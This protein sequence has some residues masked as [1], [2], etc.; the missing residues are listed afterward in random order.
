MFIFLFLFGEIV[1]YPFLLSEFEVSKILED[2]A[3]VSPCSKNSLK[4]S[5][6]VK[7]S[8]FSFELLIF[9]D[10]SCIVWFTVEKKALG[11]A[12]EICSF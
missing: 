4:L 5:I 8:P 1:F 6:V 7:N 12:I 2:P 10:E 3:V 9:Y 11:P